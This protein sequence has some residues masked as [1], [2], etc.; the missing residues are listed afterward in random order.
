M[1]VELK[2]V[3]VVR[4]RP[5]GPRNKGKSGP[6]SINSSKNESQMVCGRMKK[7]SMPKFSF[8]KIQLLVRQSRNTVEF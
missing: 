4:R 1:E 7:Y 6:F 2:D 5:M 3:E 8:S